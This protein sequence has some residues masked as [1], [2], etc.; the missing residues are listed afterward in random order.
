MSFSF[1][2]ASLARVGLAAGLVALSSLPL[3]AQETAPAPQVAAPAAAAVDPNAI[4]ATI[5]G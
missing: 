5:N 2:S 4:V 3:V 1:R